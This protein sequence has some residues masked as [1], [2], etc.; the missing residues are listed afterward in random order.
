MGRVSTAI[1]VFAGL[2]AVASPGVA[3]SADDDQTLLPA[4]AI[5][6]G[7]A[8]LPPADALEPVRRRL[9]LEHWIRKYGQWK[10]WREKWRNKS[11]P[12]WFGFRE[13]RQRPDPPEWLFEAC[14]DVAESEGAFAIACKLLADWK[15]DYATEQLRRQLIAARTE[16][17]APAKTVWWEHVHFDGLW[18]MTEW[19]ASVYGVFG[20]HATIE[21]AGRFQVF[22]AP[23]TMLV[24]LPSS[25]GGREWKPATDW[26]VTFRLVDFRFPGTNRFGTLHVNIVKAWLLAGPSN[27]VNTSI[28]LAGF[29]LSLKRSQ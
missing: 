24:N 5:A 18:P 19:R 11:E 25:R 29:S 28:D 2:A 27:V 9:E 4:R 22:V 13:R 10:E 6:V 16:A 26:G 17:E 3:Q 1:A 8:V 14:R 12:G 21:V 23:G 20:V 15:D 7:A